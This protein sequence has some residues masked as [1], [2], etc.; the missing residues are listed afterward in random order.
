MWPVY[1]ETSTRSGNNSART[2]PPGPRI[3][4]A[5]P[6]R[7]TRTAPGRASDLPSVRSSGAPLTSSRAGKNLGCCRNFW[8]DFGGNAFLDGLHACFN[9]KKMRYARAM[10]RGR[11]PPRAD[12][13][14]S[15][16]EIYL[17]MR[18]SSDWIRRDGW[19]SS[20]RRWASHLLNA[21]G[22][23]RI[24]PGARH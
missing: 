13:P 20:L 2:I 17:S 5:L 10:L 1:T 14:C 18:G 12:I 19:R 16:C 24:R 7:E 23:Q 9:H 8:G 21:A 22:G 15:S 11:K 6:L 3:S 4:Y